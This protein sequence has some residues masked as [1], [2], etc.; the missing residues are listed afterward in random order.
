MYIY[1]AYITTKNGQ[2]LYAKQY[3][4]KAFRIWV[5]DKAEKDNSVK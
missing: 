5:D 3:G 4:K 1:V 2:R